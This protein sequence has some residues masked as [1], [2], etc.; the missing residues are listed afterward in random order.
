MKGHMKHNAKYSLA[1]TMNHL[2]YFT[3]LSKLRVMAFI[4]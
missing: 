2:I 4:A 3:L 1:S